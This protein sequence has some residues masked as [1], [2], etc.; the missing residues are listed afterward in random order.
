MAF[1]VRS[2]AFSRRFRSLCCYHCDK[3]LEE[4]IKDAS[5]WMI[6]RAELE[7]SQR[8]P[9]RWEEGLALDV[10]VSIENILA[11]CKKQQAA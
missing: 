7:T 5:G 9:D 2:S 3:R 11:E 8:V 4:R 1:L 6:I 10:G